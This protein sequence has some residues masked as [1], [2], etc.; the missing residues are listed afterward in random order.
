M[1]ANPLAM[2]SDDVLVTAGDVRHPFQVP[3]FVFEQRKGME[4]IPIVSRFPDV[5]E[6]LPRTVGNLFD[7]FNPRV[8]VL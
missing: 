2:W 5:H 6:A 4:V 7:L 3:F 1:S 8:V